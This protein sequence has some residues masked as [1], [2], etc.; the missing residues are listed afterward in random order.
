MLTNKVRIWVHHKDSVVRITL[1]DGADPIT[2]FDF[3]DTDEGWYNQY[4][5]YSLLDGVVHNTLSKRGRDCDGLMESNRNFH[6]SVDG[7]T[8]PRCMGGIDGEDVYDELV[9]LPNWERGKCS[10]RDHSAE[11]MGY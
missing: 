6:W 3:G 5:V 11:A 4:D 8:S 2:L 7:T 10:Q 1:H 9:Q